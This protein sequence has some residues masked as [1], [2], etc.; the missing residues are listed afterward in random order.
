MSKP[1]IVVLFGGQ[2][3]EHI[4]SCM[5]AANVIERIDSE[6]YELLLIGITQDGRWIKA[7]DLKAVRD[8]SWQYGKVRAAISPD[9]G[10]QC[11]LL[12]EE[13]HLEKVRVDLVFPVLHGLFGEDG[14]VQGLLELARIPYV[15]CGV[16]AS[17]VSMDKWTTK[18]IADHL[19]VRQA[20]FEPVF[21]REIEED[22]EAVMDRVEAHFPYPVFVKPS[23]AGSSRGVT[24]AE[25]RGEL[26]EGLKEAACHDRKLLVEEFLLY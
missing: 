20:A 21:R 9:A 14:T 25:N 2:S 16:L 23:N 12:M 10:E 1:V 24:K 26:S 8:G 4:V 13:G 7:D 11:V 19:G 15:G 3:S 18:I 5:S 17:A 6:R 22:I